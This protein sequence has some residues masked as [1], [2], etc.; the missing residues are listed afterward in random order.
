MLSIK[1]CTKQFNECTVINNL[2]IDLFNEKTAILGENGA[3]K[4]NID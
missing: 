4:T 2:T 3:G 1:K